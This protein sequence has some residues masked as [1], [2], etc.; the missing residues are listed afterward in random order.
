MAW[1]RRCELLFQLLNWR[2]LA[3]PSRDFCQS[4]LRWKPMAPITPDILT[5]FVKR[6]MSAHSLTAREL[7]LILAMLRGRATTRE[8]AD[9]LGI[10]ESTVSNHID[11]ISSKTGLGGKSEILAHLVQKLC[12]FV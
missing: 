2:K 3:S 9:E 1:A 11:N 12:R 6:A 7:D 8:L 4:L 5:E 10:S